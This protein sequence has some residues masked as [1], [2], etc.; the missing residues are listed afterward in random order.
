MLN[1]V[2]DTLSTSWPLTHGQEEP[3]KDG[4]LRAISRHFISTCAFW[5]LGIQLTGV[6]IAENLPTAAEELIQKTCVDCHSG[7]DPES[8][9][10]LSALSIELSKPA[11]RD[12]WILIHDRIAAGEMPPDAETLPKHARQQ[13][14][15]EITKVITQADRKDVLANGRGDRKSVV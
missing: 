9:L 3:C 10:D 2:T 5:C 8:G 1:T 7:D 11:L 12:Q 15:T 13:L 4:S 14:L 6:C